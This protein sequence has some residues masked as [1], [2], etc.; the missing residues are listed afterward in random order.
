MP[1]VIWFV[2]ALMLS[3]AAEACS[4]AK[5][6]GSKWFAESTYVFRGR[7]MATS[8]TK[9][10]GLSDIVGTEAVQAEVAP[11]EIFKGPQR[12]TVSVVGGADY[13]NPVC[14]RALVAG[15]EYV[16][17]LQADMAVSSC[18]SWIADDPAL[19]AFLKTFR[20]LKAQGK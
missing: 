19:T 9:N 3:G 8:L 11:T 4:C 1:K 5:M 2:A 17:A 6:Q 16:F 10:P 12:P 15:M 13:R 18:N 7:V 14:T 20:R